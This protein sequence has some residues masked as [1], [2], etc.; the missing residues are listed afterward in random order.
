MIELWG[1][2]NAYNVQKVLWVLAELELDYSHRELGKTPGD[3]DRP[4]F[5][6]LNPHGRIPVIDDDGHVVWE[7]NTVVRYLAARYD[8]D[9][10]WPLD[11]WRRSLAERW[12]D[13]ELSRLQPDFIDLF[14]GYYRTP[15][16]SRDAAFIADARQRCDRAMR[17][18]D[19]QLAQAPFL[20]GERL[21]VADIACGVCLHRYLNLGIDVDAPEGVR[22]WYRRLASREAYAASVMT[23]FADLYGREHF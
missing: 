5:R 14:W 6:A 8:P 18:L 19:R 23:P 2:G 9:G 17:Q 3:L 12:M 16:A 13:W 15:E 10:L 7:S 11:P 20:A 4:E 22:D 1:R 21:T